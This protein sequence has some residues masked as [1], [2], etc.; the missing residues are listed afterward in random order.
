MLSWY[1]YHMQISSL[2]F[3]LLLFIFQIFWR[4]QLFYK[5]RIFLILAISMVIFFA[6]QISWAQYSLWQSIEPS[7]FLLPPYASISYFLQ[8]AAWKFWVPYVLSFLIGLIF[9]LLA[10]KYNQHYGNQFFYDDE[11]YVIWLSIFLVGHP[12]W[13]F[14]LPI[15]ILVVGLVSGA[16]SFIW[17]NNDKLPLYYFWLPVAI[18]VIIISKWLSALPLFYL[19]KV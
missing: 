3:F 14:Y 19:S 7:K 4:E 9:F 15:I 12:L 10:K 2:I 8:Y 1:D 13:I 11:L 18:F 6:I 17:K 5:I 16:R